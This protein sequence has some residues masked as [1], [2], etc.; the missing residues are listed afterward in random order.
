M[1]P[2]NACLIRALLPLLLLSGCAIRPRFKQIGVT[3]AGEALRELV[4]R[5]ESVD[6]FSANANCSIRGAFGQ[7]QFR[8]KLK[9]SAADGWF[10]K[11]TGPL[12]INLAIIESEEDEFHI[13]IPHNGSEITIDANEPVEIPG[14]ELTFPS[15]TFLTRL[16]LPVVWIDDPS[17]WEIVADK[18]ENSH[19]VYLVKKADNSLDSLVLS[20]D[21]SP[22]RLHSEEFWRGGDLVIGRDFKYRSARDNIPRAIEIHAADATLKMVF[23]SMRLETVTP[24]KP[25]V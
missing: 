14:I 3:T 23:D 13:N 15:L 25:A 17:A 18:Q 2:I 9:Y 20:L 5:S 11:M 1:R 7:F 10:V 6:Q 16:L 12:G 19:M 4:N 22:L 8:S 21:F 24:H